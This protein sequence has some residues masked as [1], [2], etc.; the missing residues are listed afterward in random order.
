MAYTWFNNNC[1]IGGTI[2]QHKNIHKLTWK[3]SD[4]KTVNQIDHVIINMSGEN[5]SMM[6]THAEAQMLKIKNQFQLLSTEEIDHP[7]VEGKWN[8]IKDVYC[9]TAKNTLGYLRSTDKT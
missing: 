6:C 4:G 5:H 8:Q 7:Q 9:N 3:S 1:V 2:F